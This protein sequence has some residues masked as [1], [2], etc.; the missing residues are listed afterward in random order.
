MR[1]LLFISI[2]VSLV[3]CTTKEYTCVCSKG[4]ISSTTEEVTIQASSKDNAHNR[5]IDKTGG[6]SGSLS[7][8]SCTLKE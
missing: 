2:V 3:L 7:G 1:K 4:Y 5:C 8:K 6:V